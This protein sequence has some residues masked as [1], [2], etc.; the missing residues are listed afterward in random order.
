LPHQLPPH[1]GAA[2]G[3]DGDPA[4]EILHARGPPKALLNQALFEQG[5]CRDQGITKQ[6]A[7]PVVQPSVL[8]FAVLKI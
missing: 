3:D 4:C 8:A 1:P 7:G 5:S 6:K 2:T